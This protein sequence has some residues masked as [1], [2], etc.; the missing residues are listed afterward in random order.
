M[1]TY[2]LLRQLA[3]SWGL[4]LMMLGF[5]AVIGWALRPGSRDTHRDIARSIFR[6]ESAPP[7]EATQHHRTEA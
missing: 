6:N 2:S 5:L 7:A 3:D 4:M 1:E